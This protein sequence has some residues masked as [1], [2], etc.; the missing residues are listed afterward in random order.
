MSIIIYFIWLSFCPRLIR[1]QK[2]LVSK[3]L[4][5]GLY[6]PDSP[7]FAIPFVEPR[8]AYA[9]HLFMMVT[10]EVKGDK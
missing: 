2:R 7:L 10:L 9:V 3:V 8:F 4:L 5:D 1:A 6:D